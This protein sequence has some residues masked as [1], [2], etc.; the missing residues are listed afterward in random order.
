M[1]IK[2]TLIGKVVSHPLFGN[3]VI[4][5]L[6]ERHIFVS[7]H[8]QEKEFSYPD[9]IGKYLTL[10]DSNLQE[11]IVS[12]QKEPVKKSKSQHLHSHN[13]LTR[14]KNLNGTPMAKNSQNKYSPNILTMSAIF[15]LLTSQLLRGKWF[16]SKLT[17]VNINDYQTENI[18]KNQG[19]NI[20]I[21]LKATQSLIIPQ[22]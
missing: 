15:V 14:I 10:E 4:S 3:G 6:T 20:P 1:M 21:Y 8:D 13:N 16:T 7:F 22:E 18:S 17:T 5:K 2:E 19:I 11:Q 9:A 12:S